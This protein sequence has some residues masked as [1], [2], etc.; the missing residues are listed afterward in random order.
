MPEQYSQ[1]RAML[2]ITKGSFR[3]IFRSPSAVVFGFAFPLVFILVFGFIGG[4]NRGP[5]YRIAIDK[6]S[7][8]TNALFDSIAGNPNIRIVRYAKDAELETD[9][10]KGRLAGVLK[11]EKN[12]LGT[13]QTPYLIHFR[14]TTASAD[15]FPQF[16]S[17]LDNI[18]NRVSN[19]VLGN[20]PVYAQLEMKEGDIK[21]VRQYKTIDFILPGQLGFSLLSAGV[22]GVAFVFFNLRQT[23]VL[24]R[25]FAT[26]IRRSYIL[27][28][29]GI[30]RVM[31]QL[32]TAIV[33]LLIGH[34][35]FNFTLVH[36]YVSRI[37]S[38]EPGGLCIHGIW[39]V[40]SGV[41]KNESTIPPLANLF[42][43]PFFIASTFFQLIIFRDGTTELPGAPTHLNDAMRNVAS[44]APD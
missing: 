9:L 41:A 5:T 37:I 8:T 35:A 4:G 10:V 27:L 18:N 25:F 6:G 12:S 31:F 38:S 40:V 21:E 43:L 44:K 17:L 14:S 16:L 22:F 26:P 33:I 42:T 24:K 36:G 23:L 1:T 30:S 7:D 32:I 3:A 19:A 13:A 15:R 28:G 39:F 29:E 11:I 34:F 20:R 2:A